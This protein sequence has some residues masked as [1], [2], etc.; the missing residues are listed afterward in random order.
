MAKAKQTVW[1]VTEYWDY[2]GEEVVGV[3][4]TRRKAMNFKK[5]RIAEKHNGG[6]DGYNI[7]EWYV[8]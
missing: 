1:I 3:F 2:E 5:R 6:G 4:A 7:T 8:Y